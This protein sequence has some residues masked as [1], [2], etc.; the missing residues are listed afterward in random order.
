MADWFD[1]PSFQSDRITKLAFF[2]QQVVPE[3]TSPCPGF[4]C[5]YDIEFWAPWYNCSDVSFSDPD[6]PFNLDDF[7]PRSKPLLDQGKDYIFQ[8]K[9]DNAT[10]YPR[11]QPEYNSSSYLG[12]G[13]FH[14]DPDVWFGVVTNTTRI[15]TDPAT[16]RRWKY[17]MEPHA[18]RCKHQRAKYKVISQWNGD[19]LASRRAEVSQ[20][21]ALF[22]QWGIT[23]LGP[24]DNMERYK[25]FTAY[26]GVASGLRDFIRGSL[27]KDN[28]TSNLVTQSFISKTRLVNPDTSEAAPNFLTTFQGFYE[29]LVLSFLSEPYLEIA[30]KQSVNCT[31]SRLENRFLYKPASLWFGYSVAIIV[32]FISSLI[33]SLAI[34]HNGMCSDT[35]FSKILVT[36]RNPTLDKVIMS[37]PGVALGGDP[38]PKELENT[39]LKFG[40]VDFKRDEP[41]ATTPLLT[42]PHTA[43]GL[44]DE[45]GT[46]N[47]LDVRRAVE[48]QESSD[49][50]LGSRG[51]FVSGAGLGALPG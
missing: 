5:T 2:S 43:F 41:T 28:Y 12:Q 20:G 15:N 18:I 9:D 31:K 32:A 46:L 39:E 36:T 51:I 49:I 48:V 7:I 40:V 27:V 29:E 21:Q 50:E 47:K 26:Y 30:N 13:I 8:M 34:R 14:G 16:M 37:Y 45:I 6:S 23:S 33:G 10:N 22:D 35:T 38:M 17:V 1:Q 44:P 24:L 3:K 19:K 4:N 42:M 25:E 11:P